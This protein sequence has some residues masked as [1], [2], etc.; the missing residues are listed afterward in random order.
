[1]I[2]IKNKTGKVLKELEQDNLRGANL[3]GANLWGAN[4]WGANLWGDD[5]EGANLQG[6]NLEGANLRYANLQGANLEGADLQGADLQG[7]NLRGANF[8]IETIFDINSIWYAESRILPEGDIIG[9]KKCIGGI[10]VK[11]LIPSDAKRSHAFD[12]KCRCE[13]AKVLEIYGSDVAYSSHDT[14]F[15]YKAGKEVRPIETFSEDWFNECAS[16]IHFFL[17]RIEAE[18][19]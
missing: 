10:I 14:T 5:L 7:A 3:Q 1:M 11:L 16:G 8:N 4:L 13:Y 12:R 9:Y 17:T 19:Y 15:V 6:A 2:Q 18:N